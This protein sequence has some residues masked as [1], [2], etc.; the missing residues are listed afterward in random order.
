MIIF[1]INAW[2]GRSVKKINVSFIS[3]NTSLQVANTQGSGK[4]WRAWSIFGPFRREFC[5][6]APRGAVHA[7]L[8]GFGRSRALGISPRRVLHA[9]IGQ[10]MGPP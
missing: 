3:Q 1:H 5:D 9:K 8:G 7:P 6:N 4:D 2:F 10:G